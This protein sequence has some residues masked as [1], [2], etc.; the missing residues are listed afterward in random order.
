[1]LMPA[2]TRQSVISEKPLG[3]S[4]LILF[5]SCSALLSFYYPLSLHPTSSILLDTYIACPFPRS[6]SH[7]VPMTLQFRPASAEWY[8]ACNAPLRLTTTIYAPSAPFD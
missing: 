3:I 8:K 6:S 4:L 7:I 5:Y 1:M 2:E